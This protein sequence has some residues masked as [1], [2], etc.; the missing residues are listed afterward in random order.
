MQSTIN[1]FETEEHRF[2]SNFWPVEIIYEGQTYPSVE[3]AYQASKT[4]DLN[5][6]EEIRLQETPG[7]AKRLGQQVPKISGWNDEMRVANM[8]ALVREK[9]SLGNSELCRQLLETGDAELIEGNTWDDTFFGVCNGVGENHLG[10]ILMDIRNDL[11]TTIAH[12]QSVLDKHR[13]RKDAADEL[14][15]SER[16]LYRYIKVFGLK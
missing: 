11:Q 15:I 7:K 14:N 2:L 13:K 12:V 8:T 9:F 1:S 4:G 6:R 10:K 3:H 16:T 5:L